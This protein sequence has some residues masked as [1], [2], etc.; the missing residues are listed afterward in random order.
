VFV[1]DTN[2]VSELRKVGVGKSHPRV[3]NWAQAVRASS[4]YLSVITV[5]ELEIGVL[6]I[7]RR[8][9]R[10]ASML[11]GWLEQQILP[12]FQGRLLPIDT[13]VAKRCAKLHVPNP[14]ADRDALI[15][16]TAL[17]HSMVV[18]TRNVADF[19]SSGVRVLNPW[20]AQPSGAH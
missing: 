14:Q 9:R 20:D 8:D 5:R 19:R 10:Q 16:A 1:L 13:A 12:Q 18:V 6:Q 15:A 11:R 2:V 3:A 17:V 4:F 7:Q